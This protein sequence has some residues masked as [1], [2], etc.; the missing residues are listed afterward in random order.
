[1]I[2]T[3]AFWAF[4]FSA[5]GAMFC[6]GQR[7]EKRFI[8]AVVAATLST[9]VANSI[10][11]ITTALPIVAVIDG[12]LLIFVLAY[13]ARSDRYWPIWFAGFHLNTIATEM[14][15]IM[16]PGALPGLYTNLAGAWALPALGAAA[17]GVM[18]D[19]NIGWSAA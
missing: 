16:F 11:G 4:L 5:C 13:V 15:S 1:M 10:W 8:I 19:R 17:W 18:R 6:F 14:G 12:A 7:D 9:F 3:I 2:L